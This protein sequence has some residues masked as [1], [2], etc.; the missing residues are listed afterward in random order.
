MTPINNAFLSALLADSTYT[1]DL[2]GLTSNEL[3]TALTP[4]MTPALAEF[5]GNNFSVEA[6]TP[7]YASG[8]SATVWV[9]K[10]DYA[11][12]VYVSMRGTEPGWPDFTADGQLATTGIAYHQ[13]EDMVNWWLRE[14]TSSY[15]MAKQIHFAPIIGEYGRR[16]RTGRGSRSARNRKSPHFCWLHHRRQRSQ[17]GRVPC[18]SLC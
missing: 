17:P 6:Q 10:G 12:Q 2:S 3:I 5:I 13:L 11:G 8:F 18:H 7:E 4:S 15:G 14:T 9:G 16:V 1:N